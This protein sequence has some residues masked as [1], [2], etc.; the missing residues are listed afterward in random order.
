MV[1]LDPQIITK[2]QK[3]GITDSNKPDK[4]KKVWE[5]KRENMHIWQATNLLHT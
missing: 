2:I 5:N 4:V 3:R 1:E